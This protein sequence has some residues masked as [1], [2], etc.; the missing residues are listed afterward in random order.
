M[1]S[2]GQKF[3]I[4]HVWCIFGFFFF[5]S[6]QKDVDLWSRARRVEWEWDEDLLV[7]G[8]ASLETLVRIGTGI[9]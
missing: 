6:R 2:V 3:L 5:V 1:R 8:R 7:N 4:F 9:K